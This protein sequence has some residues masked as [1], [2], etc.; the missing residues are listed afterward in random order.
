MKNRRKLLNSSMAALAGAGLAVAV[1][2][3]N[4]QSH[5]SPQGVVVRISRGSFDPAKADEW[6]RRMT[7]SGNNLVPAIKKLK[8]LLHYYAGIDKL[9]GSMIN[10]SVWQSLDDAKQMESLAEMGAAGREFIGAG[11]VFERPIINYQSSWT[12]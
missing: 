4:A 7:Q 2:P 3:T 8:G 5:T 12:I 9:A 11:A 10:V 1:S 6:E